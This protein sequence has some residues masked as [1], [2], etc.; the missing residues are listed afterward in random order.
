MKD[1]RLVLGVDYYKDPLFATP[2]AFDIITEDELKQ[3]T[4]SVS[5]FILDGK[6]LDNIFTYIC[7]YSF[8]L[9]FIYYFLLLFNFTLF[10]FILFFISYVFFIS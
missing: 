5:D 6:Y 8:F 10:Y 4:Q 2:L 7:I 3:A 9:Y 1:S